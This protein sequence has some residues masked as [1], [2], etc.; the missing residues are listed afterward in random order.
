MMSFATDKWFRHLREELLTEG[1]GDIGLSEDNVTRIRMELPDA[2]EKGRVWVGNALKEYG[3][4]GPRRA[5]VFEEYKD[6]EE[7]Y[8]VHFQK[9]DFN[10]LTQYAETIDRQQIKKWPKAKKSF[11]KNSLKLGVSDAI[12]N[13]VTLFFDEVE[14]KTFSDFMGKIENVV[15]TLNQNP[16]NY[17]MIKDFPPSD[18]DVAEKECYQ[19]QQNQEDP[20][21]ILHTFEDGS[22]WYD[23]QSG[24]C[25]TEADRMGH[26][27]ADSRGTLYS[28]RKKDKGKKLSK[29]YVTISHNSYSKTI[30]QIKGR[31][32]AA[33]PESV[34]GHIAWFID[35]TGTVRVEERGEHSSDQEGFNR[36]TVGLLE[37]T[38]GVEFPNSPEE[39]AKEFLEECENVRETYYN[40]GRL[41][42]VHLDGVSIE[43]P[44]EEYI[45]WHDR[46]EWI[47]VPIL[48]IEMTDVLAAKFNKDE[49]GI[50]EAIIDI[51]N[52]EDRIP[53]SD[54]RQWEVQIFS[55]TAVEAY[56][57]QLEDYQRPD[58]ANYY[59]GFYDLSGI[60]DYF[61][62][63]N[64]ETTSPTGYEEFLDIASEFVQ[65]VYQAQDNIQSLLIERKLLNRS[66]VMNYADKVKEEF[67]NFR[68]VERARSNEIDVVSSGVLFN[69]TL[70]EMDTILFALNFADHPT[71]RGG[72]RRNDYA[73]TPAF[74]NE[75]IEE[76]AK[77]EKAAADF[78]KKQMKLNYG[79][80]YEK[81]IDSLWDTAKLSGFFESNLYAGIKM[82]RSKTTENPRPAQILDSTVNRFDYKFS[83]KITGDTLPAFGPFMEYYDNNFELIT[84]AFSKVVKKMIA[85]RLKDFKAKTGSDTN[86][87]LQEARPNPIDVRIYEIDFVMSYPLGQGFEITDIHNIIR[88]IPDVTTVRSVGNAKKSQGNRTITL[89]KL[90]FALRGQK[91]RMEWVKQVLLPQIRKINSNIRIH[92]VDRA[93]LVTTSKQRLEEYFLGSSRRQSPG[94]A[95]PVPTIQQLTADWVEGG[96]MYDSPTNFNLT[97]YSVMMPVED[98]EHLLSRV[99]RK[100]GHHF[101]A[102]YQKFI[103]M[104][105]HDPIY[106]AIGKNGRAKITGNEDDLR[107][108]IKAGVEEVPVFIS[109]QRQV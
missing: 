33:P 56:L 20:D 44:H 54:Q 24:M 2:S 41:E 58:K 43:G 71:I 88:A 27:G 78:A 80:E 21:Q 10:I 82:I 61:M 1:L 65:D 85:D 105:P 26:C 86:L 79:P 9:G 94:R 36:M 90:K 73:S 53:I 98:L 87:P 63:S 16:N 35:N 95:T 97:R 93:D 29:S 15:I 32:N 52:E 109:Y 13:T 5:R 74:R 23:L 67:N 40:T 8:K 62:Y 66:G 100:H 11:I 91:N 77:S 72:L 92:K 7:A 31:S 14:G 3:L 45:Y 89:Q 101:D 51:I 46:V 81:K 50:K 30:F 39:R 4:R 22:Y 68:V 55:A 37:R 38:D 96:V 84:N 34:W 75:I 6:I 102:G 104:G 103:E 49:G 76:L 106:L 57:N 18:W 28:L 42:G 19:F 83:L 59:Y 99:P 69:T 108:A 70:D 48:S 25:S 47:V 17:E 64:G 107:Y 12:I 60:E